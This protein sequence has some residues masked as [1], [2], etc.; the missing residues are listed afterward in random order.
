LT[1]WPPIDL[2]VTQTTASVDYWAHGTCANFNY[3]H[4]TG[5]ITLTP[6]QVS[7]GS[8]NS[9]S[10]TNAVIS[11]SGSGFSQVL[12]FN[13]TWTGS[14]QVTVSAPIGGTGQVE[15]QSAATITGSVVDLGGD[16][17]VSGS[18]AT[19]ADIA[20]VLHMFG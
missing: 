18:D 19:Q 8:F 13:L 14:G 5:S 2:Q 7:L 12:T 10:L 9:A 6:D 15:R 4:M 11:V 1:S 20:E 16:T 17:L 3:P